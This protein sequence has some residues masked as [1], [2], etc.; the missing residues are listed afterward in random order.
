MEIKFRRSGKA[1]ERE[2][3]ISVTVPPCPAASLNPDAAQAETPHTIQSQDS[4]MP[5]SLTLRVPLVVLVLML[6]VGLVWLIGSKLSSTG[7]EASLPTQT[8]ASTLMSASAPRPVSTP[9]SAPTSTPTPI[10]TPTS[11]SILTLIGIARAPARAPA[12]APAFPLDPALYYS[13]GWDFYQ[14]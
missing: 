6:I 7:R 4:A 14:R 11:T 8:P 12:P 5:K 9:K 10:S 1:E 2:E 13:R 3:A